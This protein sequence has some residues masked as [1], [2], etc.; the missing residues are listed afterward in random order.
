MTKYSHYY[1]QVLYPMQNEVLKILKGLELPFY[2]TGG[3]AVSRGYLNHRYSDDLDLFTNS[4]QNFIDNVDSVIN[5]LKNN[6][7]EIEFGSS[8]P[9]FRQIFINKNKSLSKKGL[10]I[11][12]VADLVPHFGGVIETPVYYRTDSARNILS[13]KYTA[14]YRISVKDTVDIHALASQ[15]AFDW[16][17]IISEA[18]EKEGGIDLKEVCEIFSCYTI[19]HL[20]KIKWVTQKTDE[21]LEKI[22]DEISIIAKDM[23]LQQQNSL[24]KIKQNEKKEMTKKEEQAIII[25]PSGHGEIGS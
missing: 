8:S 19:D 15:Y 6:K 5:A 20:R 7:F 2:L 13:N 1:E 25:K 16:K 9:T 4:E 22:K 14:L 11:D 12:F 17:E 3:T 23:V 18:D 10:K 21:E 24:W